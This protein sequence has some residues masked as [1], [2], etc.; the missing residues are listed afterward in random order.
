MVKETDEGFDEDAD[1]G[2]R[3]K[4]EHNKRNEAKV[5]GLIDPSKSMMVNKG[6][7]RDLTADFMD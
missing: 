6:R 7:K 5:S 3:G 4:T 2:A 1:T